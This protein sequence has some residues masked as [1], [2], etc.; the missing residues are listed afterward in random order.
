VTEQPGAEIPC[1]LVCRDCG[2]LVIPFLS[3]RERGRWAAEHTAGTGH[4]RW[5]CADRSTCPTPE[6]AAAA[7]AAFDQRSD[8]LAAL[9]DSLR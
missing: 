8:L 5:F 9:L 3:Y 7:L 4:A 6:A 2:D 1:V